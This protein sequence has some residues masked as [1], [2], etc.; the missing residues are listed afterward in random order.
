MLNKI[1]TVIKSNP[2]KKMSYKILTIKKTSIASVKQFSIQQDAPVKALCIKC[3][4]NFM[5]SQL[6]VNHQ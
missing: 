1:F 5:K 4:K 3:I 2:I 6:P